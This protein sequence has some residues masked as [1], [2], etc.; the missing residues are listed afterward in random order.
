MTALPETMTAI[1]IVGKGGPEVLQPATVP[2]PPVGRGQVLIKVEA[3][4]VN[5][6]DVM[7]RLGLYPAPKGHSEIP[8]LE[9]STRNMRAVGS[10]G[11]SLSLWHAASCLTP[12]KRKSWSSQ[13]RGNAM[14]CKCIDRQR[15]L[16]DF[17]CKRGLT[18]MCRRAQARLAKMEGSTK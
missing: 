6:P 1:T 18:A 11:W 9:S 8:G 4:G 16:V 17:L 2:V 7:Q 14:A 15:K 13:S 3:A 5:R 10:T 12:S